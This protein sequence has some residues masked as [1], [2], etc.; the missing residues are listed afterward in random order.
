[1]VVVSFITRLPDGTVGPHSVDATTGQSLMQ[2]AVSAGVRGIEGECGGTMV[3]ATCH[4]YVAPEWLAHLPAPSEDELAML[5]GAAAPTR[6]GSRLA[7]QITVE[8]ALAGLV[9]E[10]PERQ[11]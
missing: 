7:C 4:V 3:C 10:V 8:P 6:A 11:Y 5:E 9:V 2:V 1:M